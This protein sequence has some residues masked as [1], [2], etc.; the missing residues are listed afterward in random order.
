M[1]KFKYKPFKT[2]LKEGATAGTDLEHAIEQSWVKQAPEPFGII[3]QDASQKI[4]NFLQNAPAKAD[5]GEAIQIGANKFPL[6]S[7][8]K[9]FGGSD[10]TPKSDVVLGASNKLR[11]SVKMGDAQLMSGAAGETTATF[12]CVAERMKIDQA[13]WFGEIIDGIE[14]SFNK[15]HTQ[16]YNV[17]TEIKSKINPEL[18]KY[19]D[20]NKKI[21]QDL[22]K[23]FADHEEFYNEFVIECMSGAMKFGGLGATLETDK[24]PIAEFVFCANPDGT[25]TKLIKIDDPGFVAKVRA[26]SKLNVRFKSNSLKEKGVKNGKYNFFSV[27]GINTSA[28]KLEKQLQSESLTESLREGIMDKLKDLYRQMVDFWKKATAWIK[29]SFQNFLDFFGLDPVVT[30]NDTFKMSEVW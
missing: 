21:Q 1:T 6:S 7:D 10:G 16:K 3:T 11:M 15:G 24:D 12:M 22:D 29:E 4:L 8:W 14:K 28:K 18:N 20:L 9:K 30:I 19:N 26:A 23:F 25:H 13:P 17:A 2:Y 5:V 27:L